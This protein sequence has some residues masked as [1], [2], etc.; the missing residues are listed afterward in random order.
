MP[1]ILIRCQDKL[2]GLEVDQL[3]GDQELVIRSLGAMIIPPRYI[4]GSCILADGRL[5]LVLDGSTLME[6]LSEQQTDHPTNSNLA[7]STS[8]ILTNRIEQPRLLSSARVAL[9]E[10]PNSDY[11]ERPKIT[12]LLVDDSITVRQTLALILQ[13]AGY[14]VLQA[15]DG[16]EAIEQL[17]YHTNIQLVFCDIEMPRMNG[18]EFLKNRQ[19]DRALA[20]IP[21][22]M[23]TSRSSEKHR[24]L[25]SQLGA[26]AYITKPYLEHM[27]LETLA[28]I[29]EKNT[30]VVAR[31][32]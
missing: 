1:V 19:R 32:E 21:V 30:E 2:L 27:L 17:R 6:S 15:K 12:I 7:S 23:V 4:Y 31:R 28:D 24:L 22:V 9:P 18:F 13:K 14:Q 20:D 25:A 26:N 10:S 16:Y 29:L 3:I 5:T 8:V 11:E